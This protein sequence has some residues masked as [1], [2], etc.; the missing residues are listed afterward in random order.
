MAKKISDKNNITLQKARKNKKDEFYTMYADIQA[1]L[2]NYTDKFTNKTVL[3]NCDDPLESNFCKFFLKN[4]NY[5]HLKRL[6]CTS[7]SGSPV[8]GKQMS[9]FDD[10]DKALI[11]EHGYV[12]DITEVPMH[13]NRGVSDDDIEKLLHSKKRG[14]K[15]LNGNGD[16]NSQECIEYL[17]QADVICTNPPFSKFREYVQL[18]VD[19]KKK[20][21]IIGSL[22]AVG[23]YKFFPLIKNN[24]VWI[25][26]SIHS[27]DRKFYVPDNYP[28]DAAG[29]GIDD[30]GRHFIKVK[31]VRWFTNIDF[32]QRHEDIILYRHY[33][34]EQ[35]KKY[36]NY[37]VIEVKKTADIPMDYD[38][39]MGLPL[40]F[41]DVYNPDQFEI[42]GATQKWCHD[43]A[44]ELKKYGNY[45][46]KHKDGTLTGRK[47][48]TMVGNPM[49]VKN[50]G[51]HD[52][53]ENEDGIQ[54]QSLY[55][56]IIIR[57]KRK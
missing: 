19:Y 1:E 32:K 23:Y 16:F 48:N 9:L 24:Q 15:K 2:N 45:I 50:D 4:F 39:L 28:L 5:L 13:N 25:G 38:G 27:G 17:E 22:N 41:I 3:C 46:G 52:Y 36:D 37:D 55:H 6:I 26:R 18:L 42:V 40:S 30:E 34:P 57:R 29:C 43:K 56:R 12:I 20:F 14:V 44:L 53:Y 47:G 51:I 33:D 8:L 21:I 7:Y 35:Y 31:G 10:Q 11:P 54:V 49:M